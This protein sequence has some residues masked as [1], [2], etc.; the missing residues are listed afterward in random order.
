MKL[1]VFSPYAMGIAMHDSRRFVKNNPAAILF[2]YSRRT[3][4]FLNPKEDMLLKRKP[5]AEQSAY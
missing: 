5:C 2:G 4:H 3:L 1:N